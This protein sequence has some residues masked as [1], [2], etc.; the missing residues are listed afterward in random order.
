MTKIN[1]PRSKQSKASKEAVS[2]ENINAMADAADLSSYTNATTPAGEAN[3]IDALQERMIDSEYKIWKKN[4]PFLYDFVLTHSL[5]WPS[6]TVEWL[7]NVTPVRTSTG[8][9]GS[10]SAG[11]GGGGST[12]SEIH[13]LL[14]GTHTAGEQNHLMIAAAVIPRDNNNPDETVA[15]A[16]A[17]AGGIGGIGGGVASESLR[18]DDEKKEVGGYGLHHG[19]A[20]GTGGGS[21]RVGKIEIKMK[22]NHEGEVHRARYMPQNHFIV[23]SRGPAPELYIWDFAKHPSFPTTDAAEQSGGQSNSPFCPQAI[24]T[25]HS[26]DGYAMAWSPH[27]EGRLVSG[28]EDANLLLWDVRSGYT[29]KGP[30]TPLHPIRTYASSPHGHLATIEDVAWH[31]KDANLIGSVADDAS[32]CLW[33]IRADTSLPMKRVVQAHQSDINC[34]AFNP[35][36]EFTLATGGAGTCVTN[37]Q[38]H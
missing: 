32:L 5:E 16:A 26:K 8:I 29:T 23:A 21:S 20:G 12:T 38:N 36:A 4:T 2:H 17:A 10:S 35:V 31:G 34:L 25:G 37:E 33:D 15:A 22:I 13:H 30:G 27:T 28:S 9:S 19:G 6:L 24:C 3:A 1:P 11:G 14:I 7:P 18:Y